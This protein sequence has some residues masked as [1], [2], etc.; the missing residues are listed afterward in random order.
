MNR[1][2]IDALAVAD[3]I[4]RALKKGVLLTTKAGGK[5][6]TM[7]IGWGHVGILWNRPVFV[8]YVRDSRYTWEMLNRDPEFTVNVPTHGLDPKVFAICGSRSGRDMDKIREA[9]LT[10]VDPEAVNVPA[11]RECPLTLECR[12]FYRQVQRASELPEAIRRQFYT[13]ETGDHTAFYGEILS[14]YRLKDEA[15]EAH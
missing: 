1:Q 7:V 12:V 10:L 8:A 2:R 15:A 5:V 11:I 13:L 4:A 6:N 9:G 14:A 3:E